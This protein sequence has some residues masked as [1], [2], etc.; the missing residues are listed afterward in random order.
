MPRALAS[1]SLRAVVSWCGNRFLRDEVLPLALVLEPWA[2]RAGVGRL[3][4]CRASAAVWSSEKKHRL[5]LSTHRWHGF[6]PEHCTAVRE[7]LQA[8][9]REWPG[10][11]KWSRSGR[12]ATAGQESSNTYLELGAPA[13]HTCANW[14]ASGPHERAHG[15]V[16]VMGSP[17]HGRV[18]NHRNGA[19]EAPAAPTK[20]SHLAAARL[21][22]FGR[23]FLADLLAPGGRGPSFDVH[24]LHGLGDAAQRMRLGERRRSPKLLRNAPGIGLASVILVAWVSATATATV[25]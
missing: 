15:V 3:R 19:C 1:L 12:Q 25:T 9:S 11:R 7:G 8:V 5:P 10:R 24:V 21:T 2:W 16:V 14:L 17:C 22:G 18:R 20:R 4:C 6:S 13:Q 23:V